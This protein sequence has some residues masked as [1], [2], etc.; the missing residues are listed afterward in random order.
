MFFL[1]SDSCTCGKVGSSYPAIFMFPGHFSSLAPGL[2]TG[3]T[4]ISVILCQYIKPHA[5]LYP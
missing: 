1:L 5:L 2:V 4:S 3:C